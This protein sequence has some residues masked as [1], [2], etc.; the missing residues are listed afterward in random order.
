MF[1]T[2]F[3]IPKSDIKRQEKYNLFANRNKADKPAPGPSGCKLTGTHKQSLLLVKAISFDD[4][5]TRCKLCK[6]L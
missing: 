5:L 3:L 4:G 6:E 2:Y 1:P